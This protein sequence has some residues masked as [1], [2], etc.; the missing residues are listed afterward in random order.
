MLPASWGFQ[1]WP[2]TVP[3]SVHCLNPEKQSEIQRHISSV[4]SV[5]YRTVFAPQ[6]PLFQHLTVFIFCYWT[7]SLWDHLRSSDLQ[8]QLQ[9]MFHCHCGSASLPMFIYTLL[10]LGS[11]VPNGAEVKFS[12]KYVAC[13]F[14]VTIWSRW[15]YISLWFAAAVCSRGHPAW[16]QCPSKNWLNLTSH[17]YLQNVSVIYALAHE[18]QSHS[19]WSTSQTNKQTWY[20]SVWTKS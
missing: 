6:A 17:S 12:T 9:M 16:F 5:R 8:T 4:S 7:K 14:F 2:H 20:Y 11:H 10:F 19:V 3:C 18:I 1:C 15:G 13:F